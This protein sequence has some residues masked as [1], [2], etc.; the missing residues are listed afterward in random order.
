MDIEGPLTQTEYGN[1]YILTIQDNLTKYS[2]AIPLRSTESIVIASAFAE[3]FI[4]RFGCPHVIRTDQGSNFTS[5]V[6]TTFCRIFKI[7]SISDLLH[8]TLKHLGPWK[9]AIT[10]QSNT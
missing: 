6:M 7:I 4:T 8:S 9:E 1:K 5:K 10:F 3:N 2:D